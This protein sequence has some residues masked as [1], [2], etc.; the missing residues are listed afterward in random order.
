M[1]TLKRESEHQDPPRS[2]VDRVTQ[3]PAKLVNS[4][5]L[6]IIRSHSVPQLM[7]FQKSILGRLFGRSKQFASNDVPQVQEEVDDVEPPMDEPTILEPFIVSPTTAKEIMLDL[8]DQSA[9]DAVSIVN[10]LALNDVSKSSPKPA[11]PGKRKRQ[12]A[13]VV[14]G[15][16]KKRVARGNGSNRTRDEPPTASTNEITR[17]GGRSS[18]A[19]SEV[20]QVA[21][22]KLPRPKKEQRKRHMVQIYPAVQKS[23]DMWDPAPSPKKQVE[24]S[25]QP[26]TTTTR[27]PQSPEATPRPRG[28]PPGARLSSIKEPKTTKKSHHR[29][30]QGIKVKLWRKGRPEG[31]VSPEVETPGVHK[32]PIESLRRKAGPKAG[33]KASR[34][35]PSDKHTNRAPTFKSTRST[36][37]AN[38]HKDAILNANIDLTKKPERDA[39]RAAKQRRS[40][41]QASVS[42]LSRTRVDS[43]DGAETREIARSARHGGK[44]ARAEAQK[45]SDGGQEDLVSDSEFS[46]GEDGEGTGAEEDEGKELED[47]VASNDQMSSQSDGEQEKPD[48]DDSDEDDSDE[49]D[50]DE[51]DSDEVDSD[52][53]DS[54][55]EDP[56]EVQEN[57]EADQADEDHYELFGQERAWKTVLEGAGSVCGAKLLL[58]RM[59]KL[60]TDTVKALVNDV[61][62]ARGLYEQLL[63]FREIDHGPL[64]GIHLQLRER[65]D[66]I[67]NRIRSLSEKNAATKGPEM[68]RDIYAR[69]IPAMVFLLQSALTSR[70]YHSDEPCDLET[71]NG[72]V[73]GLKEIVRLQYMT[74]LLCE[75][76]KRWKSK[77]VPTSRPIIKPI[78]QKIYPYLRVI[79]EAFA[80][81]LSEQERKRKLKQ[82]DVDSRKKQNELVQLAQQVKQEAARR[83]ETLHRRIRESREQEDERRRNE[84]RTLKQIREDEVHAKRRARQVNGHVESSALWSNAEDLELYFQLEKG[85]SGKLTSTFISIH[86]LCHC[87]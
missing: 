71:L 76:A 60:L 50:S 39:R 64:D 53:V 12:E 8:P 35:K 72:N 26:L 16:P 62:E 84:K 14:D 38:G 15:S 57:E 33:S 65:L 4:K 74:I 9:E 83:N 54:D 40:L 75:K 1:H 22:G 69:A 43:L 19:S 85:Y 81:K 67:E 24:K 68:I 28:R 36:A 80:Q 7:E 41:E 42:T 48:E 59:P 20:E 66:A 86:L 52:E 3:W 44:T 23:G 27:N 51:D 17:R 87:C 82:N 30:T 58:N 63:P 18:R 49:D 34:S 73:R 70:I 56:S 2:A 29:P 47:A 79:R 11:V 10:D 6:N 46:G 77:P 78:T 37:A 61:R 55:S 25:T 31:Y 32:I 45:A 13:D 21:P 5:P